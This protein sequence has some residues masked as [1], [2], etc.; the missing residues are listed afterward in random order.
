MNAATGMAKGGLGDA[1]MMIGGE[2][3][4]AVE[5][6]WIDIFDPADGSV[7]ARLARGTAADVDRAVVAATAAQAPWAAL[8]ASD[9]GRLLGAIGARIAAE[10]EALA[11]LESRDTGKPLSQARADIGAAARYFEFYAGL[12]DKVRGTTLPLGDGYVDY[13]V[14]EPFG[15]SGQIVPWNYPMQIGCRGIAPALAAGNAVVVKPAEDASLSLL[16]V[17]ELAREEGLAAGLL[18]VV[19]GL[20]GEA[21]AALTAH[22]GIGQITFTGSVATGIEV[23]RAGAGHVAPVTLELGGKCP[24]VVFDDADLEAA[25]PVLLGAITQNAGQ[26]CSAASRLIVQR[27]AHQALVEGI[28]EGMRR[29]RLGAGVEDPDMGPLINARQRRRVADYVDAAV[30]AGVTL[31]TGGATVDP[32]GLEGGFFYEPTLLDEVPADAVIAREEVFGPVLSVLVFDR[33]EEAL[34]LANSTVYGL[35]CGVWT[36][37]V[38]RAHRFASGV[39]SGQVFI[40]SYGAAGGVELPFGG[41]GHSGYGREKGIEGIDSYLQTK[42]VCVRVGG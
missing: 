12:A 21:G 10:S 26:T 17:A 28:A 32:P 19:T 18:N 39:R 8:P 37:D 15:V 24:N 4:D 3:R 25:V 29:V 5:G 20:G 27:G 16:R 6:G 7:M 14:R 22:P 1:P 42:N 23:A 41:Y 13:T 2:R 34:E 30:A 11:L 31:R 35:V 33:E 9:R 40:N 38:G 36:A